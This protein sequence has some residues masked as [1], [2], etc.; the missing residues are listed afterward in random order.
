M[1]VLMKNSLTCVFAL[2]MLV[3]FTVPAIAQQTEPQPQQAQ[4]VRDD[5]SSEELENFVEVVK[6]QQEKE[7]EM[8]Q[9]IQNEGLEIEEFNEILQV[10]QNPDAA[11]DI[12]QEEEEKF[13]K[14]S[15]QVIKLQQEMQTEVMQA[16]NETGLGVQ[17]YQAIVS[18]YQTNPEIQKEIDALLTK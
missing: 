11:G 8:M 13:A 9:A 5:F 14:A 10:K 12:P 15:E 17:T 6:V 7:V 16:I 4:E 18:A 2:L 1:K 3:A